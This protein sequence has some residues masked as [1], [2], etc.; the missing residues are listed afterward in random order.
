MPSFIKRPNYRANITTLSPVFAWILLNLITENSKTQSLYHC[1]ISTVHNIMQI[2]K[3][4]AVLIHIHIPLWSCTISRDCCAPTEALNHN[5]I[6]ILKN[7]HT[8]LLWNALQNTHAVCG[9]LGEVKSVCSLLPEWQIKQK[10]QVV[11]SFSPPFLLSAPL[12]PPRSHQAEGGKVKTGRWGYAE[13][14]PTRIF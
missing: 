4:K 1:L 11:S 14:A 8:L 7:Q 6:G 2:C 10:K 13:T 3:C 12:Q 9:S 5:L